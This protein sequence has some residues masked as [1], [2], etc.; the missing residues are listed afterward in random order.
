MGV[1]LS[2][3]NTYWAISKS[4]A[5]CCAPENIEPKAK[6]NKKASCHKKKTF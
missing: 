5:G 4:T 6:V 3:T 1:S 2:F